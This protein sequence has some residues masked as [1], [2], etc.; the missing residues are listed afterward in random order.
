VVAVDEGVGGAVGGGVGD[1]LGGAALVVVSVG[2]APNV[3]PNVKV[4]SV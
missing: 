1:G 2:N 4:V 3:V